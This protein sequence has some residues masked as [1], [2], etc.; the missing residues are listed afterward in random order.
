MLTLTGVEPRLLG[1]VDPVEDPR[2]REVDAVHRAEDRVVERVEADGHPLAGRRRAS[3]WASA[4][5]AEPFVVSVR[6]SGPP[7]G[8]AEGRQ[9][10]DE[11]R[12]VAPDERLAAGDPQL[13]DAELDEGPGDPL[14][15]L[16]REDLVLRE[17]REVAARRS[18]SACS[19]CSGSCSDR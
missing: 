18:P 16:E 1:R 3:G 4:R 14:D 6:S 11:D 13:L 9:H 10:R 19:T 7:S 2:D 15:L 8:R 12:Q 17:E 5:S